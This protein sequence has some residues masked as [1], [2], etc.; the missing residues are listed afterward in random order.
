MVRLIQIACIALTA[1]VLYGINKAVDGIG[2]L[3][4]GSFN[5]G[6]VVGVVFSVLLYGLICLLDPSSRPRGT[7]IQ[8]QGFDK[9]V[10]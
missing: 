6:F 9:R 10:D 5:W 2:Y 7:G 1:A 8:Q 3:L 4:G